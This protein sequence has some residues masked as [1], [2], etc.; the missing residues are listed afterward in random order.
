MKKTLFI[1]AIA[2]ALV[3]IGSFIWVISTSNSEIK[4][5]ARIKGQQEMTEAFYTKLWEVLT[6]KANVAGEYAN[7][8][9]DIQV[10]I[11]EGRYSTGGSLMKWIK[12]ANPNFDAS[13]Y[14]D[15][16]NSI[17][18]QREGFFIE[19]QKLRDMSVQHEIML[20]T[21][22]S[23]IVIGNREPIKVIILK[24]VAT[25]Q[26]YETGVDSSPVLFK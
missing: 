9:K 12:E 23:S 3:V 6:T 11:M 13:L 18:A 4:L 16:M 1:V 14:K 20:N 7:K 5:R 17:E 21:W 2:V 22:P 26:A 19:Q 25:K 15:V 24:K 8:F 10:A